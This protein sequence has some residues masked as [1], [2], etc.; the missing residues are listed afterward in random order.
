MSRLNSMILA[1]KFAMAILCL[2]AISQTGCAGYQVGNRGLFRYDVNTVHVPIFQSDSLRR[3]LGERLTEAV[4]K[5]IELRTP[6]KV[7]TFDSADSVIQ[8]LIISD[9]KRVLAENRLD[10]PRDILANLRVEVAWT[11]RD[12]QPLFARQVIRID[13]AANFIPE[14]GQSLTTAQQEVINRI[15]SEIVNQ[16]EVPSL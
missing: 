2:I 12:N 15:A 11:K 8:G 3:Y 6:Y 16:M 1:F 7:T 14:G 13:D 4:V 9:R 5:E 10:E